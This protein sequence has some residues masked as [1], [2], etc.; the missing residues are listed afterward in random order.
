MIDYFEWHPNAADDDIKVLDQDGA[1]LFEERSQ[2]AASLHESANII[3]SPRLN[4]WVR[5]L[6][7]KTIDG[8]T[9]RVYYR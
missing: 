3:R 2:F 7:V 6:N 1:T 5:A 4:R 8:G 9:L